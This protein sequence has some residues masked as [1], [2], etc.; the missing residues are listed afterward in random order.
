MNKVS[1]AGR[2]KTN[3]LSGLRDLRGLNE[4]LNYPF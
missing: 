4:L 2:R 3:N 1:H